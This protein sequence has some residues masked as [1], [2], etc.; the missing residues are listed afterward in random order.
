[1]GAW[2]DYW[3]NHAADYNED[4]IDLAYY[5]D[6]SFDDEISRII[7]DDMP[8]FVLA[9]IT[10][11]VYLMFTL[12]KISCIGARP[13]LAFSAVWVMLCALAIGFSISI[14]IGTTLIQL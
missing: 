8:I 9:L 4:D 11:S 10:M 3:E 12:G 14:V 5:T 6:R 2:Q 1:M 7:S 13:W